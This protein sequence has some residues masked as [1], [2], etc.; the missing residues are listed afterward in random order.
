MYG[1]IYETTNLINGK[2]YIGQHKGEYDLEYYGSGILLRRALEK[3]GKENFSIRIIEKCDSKEQLNDREKYWIQYYNASESDEFYNIAYGGEGGSMPP[4]SI[5]KAKCKIAGQKRS[6]KTKQ[7][8]SIRSKAKWSNSQYRDKQRN[9]NPRMTGKQHSEEAKK[10]MSKSHKGKLCGED[11]P[12]FGKPGHMK[13]KHHTEETKQK[14]SQSR[15]GKCVGKD[16]PL[17]GTTRPQSVKDAI[18]KANKGKK[19]SEE[20]KRKVSEAMK[21]KKRGTYKRRYDCI[22]KICNKPF[23]GL[24]WNSSICY[25]CRPTSE[26]S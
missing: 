17:Y 22:C 11:N 1:Y 14:I 5:E 2:K 21:G 3:Y 13:G 10:K 18:S 19:H 24:S 23:E 20:T 26:R 8:M 25:E 15:T 16:N 9:N 7:I 12:M 4:E 6:Q